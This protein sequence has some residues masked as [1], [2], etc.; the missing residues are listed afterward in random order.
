MTFNLDKIRASPYNEI[1]IQFQKGKSLWRL[2]N[3]R[4]EFPKKA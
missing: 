2:N 3:S 1:E 4:P